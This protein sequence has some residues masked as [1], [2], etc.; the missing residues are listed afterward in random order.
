MLD[1]YLVD[2]GSLLVEEFVIGA[3]HAAVGLHSLLWSAGPTAGASGGPSG[4]PSAGPSAGLSESV[5]GWRDGTA[6]S[7]ALRTSPD[8]PPRVTPTDRDGAA[9]AVA[10]P[11]EPSLRA[12]FGPALPL[13]VAAPLRFGPPDPRRHRYRILFAPHHPA[14]GALSGHHRAAGDAY[15]WQLRAVGPGLAW[16]L[17]VTVD[18][19]GPSEATIDATLAHLTAAARRT[20][21]IP[22]TTERFA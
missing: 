3:D 11:A 2:G 4:G 20:G 9:A 14:V 12:M 10:L 13:P 21:L 6:F 17:D 19:A 18:L 1:Y 16:A 5:P 7:R 8:L 15:A 22:I